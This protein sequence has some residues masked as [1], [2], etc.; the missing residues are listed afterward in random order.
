ME[1]NEKTVGD[2]L[3]I[4]P[5]GELMGGDEMQVFL[6]R[7]YETIRTGQVR[8]VVDMGEVKWM[9]SSGLGMLMSAL[10]TLRGSEGDLCLANI[11]DRVR[12]PVEVTRL[13]SVI[14]IYDTV[15]EAVKHFSR[16]G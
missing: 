12:R 6:D 4:S 10:T 11:S 16:G 15:D 1:M 5:K 3:I 14:K 7:I 13:N 2:V 9:N 8:V